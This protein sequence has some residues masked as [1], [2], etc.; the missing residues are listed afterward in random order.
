[1]NTAGSCHQNNIPPGFHFPAVQPIDL[2]ELS[3]DSVSGNGITELGRYGKTRS[4]PVFS[5]PSAVYHEIGGYGTFPFGVKTSEIAVLF[6]GITRIQ[7][8]SPPEKSCEIPQG[9]SHHLPVKPLRRFTHP[10]GETH[11]EELLHPKTAVTYSR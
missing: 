5:V 6:Y 11:R 7:T 2:P 3:S 4:V 1:M 9:G 8:Q 10:Q